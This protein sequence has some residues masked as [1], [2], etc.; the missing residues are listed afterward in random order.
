MRVMAERTAS[1]IQGAVNEL[2]GQPDSFPSV[3]AKT[4]FP[5]AL[6]RKTDFQWFDRL[7]MARQALL[8]ERCAVLPGAF[9]GEIPMA[10][11]TRGCIHQ[12]HGREGPG[13]DQF[14][15]ILAARRQRWLLVENGPYLQMTHL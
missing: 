6:I 1:N 12:S 7:L 5:D 8:I 2:P 3:A 9:I 15:A 10:G 13:L 11:N 14:M 4:K